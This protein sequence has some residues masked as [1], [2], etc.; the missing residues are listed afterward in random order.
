MLSLFI[1]I[2]GD[3]FIN[4]AAIVLTHWQQDKKAKRK[5]RDDEVSEEIKKSL[6]NDELRNMGFDIK[7]NLECFFIDNKIHT[8]P[9]EDIIELGAE[10]ELDFLNQEVKKIENFVISLK[11]FICRDIQECLAFNDQ[12]KK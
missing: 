5:R 8:M 11:P 4:N 10:D 9:P 7:K 3:E 6:F 2:F 12:L 1:N